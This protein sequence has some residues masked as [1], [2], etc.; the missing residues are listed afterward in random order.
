MKITKRQLDNIIKETRKDLDIPDVVGAVTGVYGEENR[1]RLADLGD[2]FS[3]MHKEL[4]GRRPNIPM[5]KTTEEAESA[6]DEL[7]RQY[8]ASNEAQDEMRR[9]DLEYQTLEKQLQDL[10]PDE[11]D[12]E[13]PMSSGMGHR[14][15]GLIRLTSSQL[16]IIIRE[17][18][19]L[20][21]HRLNNHGNN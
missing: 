14:T 10:M 1:Q 20:A 5:F 13:S 15:E 16:R 12:I 21:G 7:W 19:S 11:Y 6:V 4:Y 9:Q 8:R 17:A 2:T 18:M 3:D